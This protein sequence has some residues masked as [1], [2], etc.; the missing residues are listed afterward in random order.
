MNKVTQL[1]EMLFQMS[2][3]ARSVVQKLIDDA[4]LHE[5]RQKL[6][7]LGENCKSLLMMFA[8]G[9]SDKEIATAMQYN[10]ADVVKTSRLRCLQKLRVA[11][12][13]MKKS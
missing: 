7:R 12:S 5:M 6:A 8:E 10:S 1:P 3:A 9:F 13:A 4:D 2:D 11:Y